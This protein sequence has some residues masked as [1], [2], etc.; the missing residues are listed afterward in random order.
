[1]DNYKSKFFKTFLCHSLWLY[2]VRVNQVAKFVTKPT[3]LQIQWLF[4]R[5]V[6]FFLETIISISD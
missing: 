2:V 1:M 6:L 3:N 4:D 5:P